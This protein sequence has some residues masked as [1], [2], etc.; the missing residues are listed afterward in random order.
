MTTQ[1]TIA[2]IGIAGALFSVIAFH[3]LTMW[4]TKQEKIAGFVR[5]FKSAFTHELSAVRN[6]TLME[7]DFIESF[8]RYQ[9]AFNVA[10]DTLT[11]RDQRK[12]KKAWDQYCG[13]DIMSDTETFIAVYSTVHDLYPDFKKRFDNLYTCLDHLL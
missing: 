5:D 9:S 1:E 10:F 4:R 8:D 2:I 13:K 6:N 7:H 11:K 3:R 12:L